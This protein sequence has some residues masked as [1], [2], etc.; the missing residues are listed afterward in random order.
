MRV[1]IIRTLQLKKA[2]ADAK[3][4]IDMIRDEGIW[5]DEQLDSDME[6]FEEYCDTALNDI[7]K[8]LSRCKG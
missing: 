3:L 4:E 1:E 8:A 6:Y 2:I 7:E 5:I